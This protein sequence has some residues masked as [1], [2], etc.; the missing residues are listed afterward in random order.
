MVKS[1]NFIIEVM[2]P[3]ITNK[4]L[5]EGLFKSEISDFKEE[6]IIFKINNNVELGG[7][8]NWF[9]EGQRIRKIKRMIRQI[10]QIPSIGVPGGFL[11]I[12]AFYIIFEN[13]L[14]NI[15]K[16]Q[17][18][19][20]RQ[21]LQKNAKLEI[22]IELKESDEDIFWEME[23][24]S[25]IPCKNCKEVNN[26][27]IEALEKGIID[28]TSGQLIPEAWGT[29]EML[30]AAD[31]LRGGP[32]KIL[33]RQKDFKTLKLDIRNN[34]YLSYKFKVLKPLTLSI[35]SS[36]QVNYSLKKELMKN[37]VC[38]FSDL[39]EIVPTEYLITQEKLEIWNGRYPLKIYDKQ[40][41]FENL[42]SE[43]ELFHF[44]IA[45]EKEF[46]QSLNISQEQNFTF[47]IS[48]EEK[49]DMDFSENMK[50]VLN[51][52][53]NMKVLS[54]NIDILD[55]FEVDKVE[56]NLQNNYFMVI[57]D[58]HGNKKEMIDKLW[59]KYKE[60]I[61]WEPYGGGTST[62][63]T[64]QILPPTAY[65][66]I[67]L[68]WSLISSAF[69]KV[70]ILDE[71]IQQNLNDKNWKY[72][73]GHGISALE[74][75]ERMR[76]YIP[77][78]IDLEHPKEEKIKEFIQEKDPHIVS[79]HAGVLDKMGYKNSQD[80]KK[81]IMNIINKNRKAKRVIIHSGRGIPSNV[82]ELEIPFI[83]FTALEHWTTSKDLKSK[84]QLTQELLTSRGVKRK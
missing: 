38:V 60:K 6:N 80:V 62:A 46:L 76:I 25:N 18:E 39:P 77:R 23:I 15:S 27:I 49:V 22:N 59:N 52:H 8:K 37:G 79:I 16:H 57:F 41:D 33:Q 31:Y 58:R 61:F 32:L 4:F 42:N 47:I 81:W 24:Y 30:I 43:E 17:L 50:E 65:R 28:E 7:D 53:Q 64:L 29:K 35:H 51:Q 40:A 19:E 56:K 73:E 74:C 5:I 48:S 75:L 78:C 68:L 2:I 83:G 84:Y 1:V 82:P 67:Y 21:L 71:R 66:K 12:H 20:I 45:L 72:G 34:N 44:V 11:G 69:L 10:Q 14:R 63:F 36:Q 26:K 3:F 13:F 54:Q 9:D 55:K 70:A